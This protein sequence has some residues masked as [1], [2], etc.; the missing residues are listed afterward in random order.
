MFEL[1][2]A[3]D[4]GASNFGWLS[5]RHTFSFGSYYD[6]QQCGFSDLLVINDDRVEAGGG[7]GSHSHREMEIFSYVLAGNLEHKDSLGNGSIIRAGDVQI[8]SAGTGITH[9]EFNHSQVE[10]VHF[11]QIWI[12]PNKKDVTP[13]YQ[14]AHFSSI[15]KRG[16]LCT[17]I[18]GSGE[19]GALSVY[20][21]ICV[22]AGCFDAEECATYI[23]KDRYAY[24]HLA[25]GSL[26]VNGLQ[27]C[28]GDGMRVRN[29]NLIEIEGG[30]NAELLVFDL[31]PNETP[32]Q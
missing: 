26:K 27:L 17:I 23:I 5:S 4:R 16:K 3:C 20:Q 8:M 25:G 13:R 30:I 24:L 29:E 1:R 32:H 18:S 15:E 22:L 19:N 9:S 12:L 7:F 21:N 14:Q 10:P 28:E 2:K 11:I 31:R 6:P